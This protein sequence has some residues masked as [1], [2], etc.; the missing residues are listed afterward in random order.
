MKIST[1][2]WLVSFLIY[3]RIIITYINCKYFI[4]KLPL[5]LGIV[6]CDLY[7][8]TTRLLQGALILIERISVWTDNLIETNLRN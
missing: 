6:Y 3:N 7:L 4:L 8:F 5:R 2:I 1:L